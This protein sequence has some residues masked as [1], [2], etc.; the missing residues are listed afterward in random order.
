VTYLKTLHQLQG[1]CNEI[2]YCMMNLK[3]WGGDSCELFQGIIWG[4]WRNPQYL[5]YTIQMCYHYSF[6]L[7]AMEVS[8]SSQD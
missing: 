1:G 3:C 4:D 6:L 5:L 8:Q 7:V 2:L